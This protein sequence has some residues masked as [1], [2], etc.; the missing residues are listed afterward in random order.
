MSNLLPIHAVGGFLGL[1]RSWIP[2]MLS[3]DAEGLRSMP[4]LTITLVFPPQQSMRNLF[5]VWLSG[6]NLFGMS[7]DSL[8]PMLQSRVE[9]NGQR[10]CSTAQTSLFQS[11]TI[12]GD[13]FS[14]RYRLQDGQRHTA[15]LRH[16][17]AKH[18]LAHVTPVFTFLRFTTRFVK[19]PCTHFTSQPMEFNILWRRD[20]LLLHMEGLLDK[21]ARGPSYFW[22]HR[23]GSEM[24]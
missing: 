14:I 23:P 10:H 19:T 12:L 20:H 22:C 24:V 2:L 4:V 9:L 11:L 3:A 7:W 21:V 6:L 18:D 17:L 8:L 1:I 16:T 5:P 13:P 15:T